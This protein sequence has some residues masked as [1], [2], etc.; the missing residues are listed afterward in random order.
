MKIVDL[1]VGMLW[2]VGL[3]IVLAWKV[4]TPVSAQVE[5]P[6][7]TAYLGDATS[8]GVGA[9]TVA[10][11]IIR[12]QEGTVCVVASPYNAYNITMQCDFSRSATVKNQ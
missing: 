3:C 8:F 4:S 11:R 6:L 5:A 9:T 1:I 7:P 2:G 12:F 10:L